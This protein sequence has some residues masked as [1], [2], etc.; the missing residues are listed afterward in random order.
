MITKEGI[1]KK[2]EFDEF[3]TTPLMD[4]FDVIT[5]KKG[6]RRELYGQNKGVAWYIIKGRVKIICYFEDGKELF[7]EVEEG[8]WFGIEDV[9][10]GTYAKYDA[11]AYTD[12]LVVEVPMKKILDKHS[13][14]KILKRVMRDMAASVRIRGI[15]AA[16][17]LSCGNEE[18]FLKYLEKNDF[19]LEYNNIKELSEILNIRLRTFQRI[20][21]KLTEKGII[22][23]NE[24]IIK[25]PDIQTYKE[26]METF[27]D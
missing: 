20:L 26:Y 14:E 18:F 21:K 6:D 22:A 19:I 17:K 9:V 10:L 13:S 15:K 11:E 12:V 24:K 3:I 23:K 7:W 25:V 4:D 8:E 1:L 16:T 5:S 27:I 2:L